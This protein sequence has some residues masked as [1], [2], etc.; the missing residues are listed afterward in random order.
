MDSLELTIYLL[1]VFSLAVIV[2]Y[3]CDD[4]DQTPLP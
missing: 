3:A 2:F 1:L 4:D